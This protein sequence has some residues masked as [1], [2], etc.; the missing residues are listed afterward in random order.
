MRIYNNKMYVADNIGFIYSINLESGNP[1]WIKNHGVPLKSKIKV[2]NGKI[3]LI[4]Q[5][6]R[7]LCLSTKDGSLFW[8]IR[9]V[10]SFIKSQSFLSLALSRR[11]D[12]VSIDTSGNLMKVNSLNG[13]VSWTLNATGS[14]LAHSTDFFKSSDIV[15]SDQNIYFS[16]ES[17]IFSYSLNNG[18]L[19]W[20][21]DI[22]SASTPIVS[23]NN[24][25]FVTENG[26]F[27]ILDKITGEL[28]SSNYILKILKKRKRN[29]QI[30]GF[31]MG[32]GNIYA[33]TFNGYLISCS[34]SSGLVLNFMKVGKPITSSPIINDGKLFIYTEGSRLFGFN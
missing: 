20:K 22:S 19:N 4:N 17:S 9:S 15:I 34:A 16:T 13:T 31:I 7:L 12:L 33:V 25:F 30:T 8:N 10:K 18:Y 23:G 27:V 28:V 14:M 1:I 26:Y 2:L 24:F 3:Y 21:K 29:T 11:D 6:N 32:S 5:D